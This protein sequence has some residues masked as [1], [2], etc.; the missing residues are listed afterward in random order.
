MKQLLKLV[1]PIIGRAG[2]VKY[3]LLGI[4][5]GLCS[6]LFINQV[7]KVIGLM[8]GGSLTV[9]SR[10]YIIIFASIILI[11]VWARRTLS[12]TSI[13]ISLKISWSLRKQ[14]LK[15]VINANYY[16]LSGRITHIQ[17]AILNDVGA[18]TNASLSV[19]DFSISVILAVSCFAY[20]A[21]I[22]FVLFLITFFVAMLGIAVYYYSSKA[23]M[24]SL[25]KSRKM[26][27]KF[28]NNLNDILNGFKEIFMDT[29][30]GEFIYNDRISTNAE[31]SFKHSLSAGTGFINNQMTGQILF[32]ILISSVLLIFSFL[33]EI[34]PANVVT[35][36]FSLLYL[37]G[38]IESIMV[39]LPSLM[40][41]KV[42]ADQLMNLRKEL[43]GVNVVMN[44][45]SN[46]E[47]GGSFEELTVNDLEFEY[48][49]EHSFFNIGPINLSIKRQETIFI[50]GGNGSGKTTFI[51]TLLGLCP[52]TAG[53]IRLNNHL[54]QAQNYPLFKRY[55]SVV[56]SNFYLFDEILG[57]EKLDLGKWD[58]Y[59]A[60]FEIEDKVTLH[61][62]C[63]S[64]VDLSAGQR[65]RLALVVCL[66]ENKPIL[67]LDEWA[68]D[69]DPYF[70]KKF[71]TIILPL[72]NEA[73]FTIIAI[74]HD[75]K[76]YGYG[77]KLFK[78]DEGY[79]KEEDI[80]SFRELGFRS[81]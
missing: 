29:K 20:L 35:F 70:R 36:I 27:N 58:Y 15:L 68:A 79:L 33:L 38:S 48:K 10:D 71:Y 6:F 14:I 5:T 31:E 2:A 59:L 17:T 13:S 43:E 73:G 67:V 61:E 76:Y 72:L 49:G 63:L 47:F 7:T 26:E 21:S 78:M 74:T 41:A 50:Y 45:V 46:S 19:I 30:K 77:S 34:K 64:T 8:I 52:P 69:Q 22:S 1:L 56:F 65:K 80:M 60:L 3:I 24:K 23:N 39:Q 32:Y 9:I 44:Q 18:L 37:L 4:V 12:L 28:Q 55:F 51:H 66:M 42:A 75:D 81:N 16:Q 40:R 25:E 11:Y 57:S 62:R 54:L 53:E